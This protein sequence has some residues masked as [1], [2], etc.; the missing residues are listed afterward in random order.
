MVEEELAI[1]GVGAGL[2]RRPDADRPRGGVVALH[3]A[4]RPERSQPLFD[5]LADTLVPLGLAVL[6]YDRRS[7][8][9]DSDIPLIHQSAD[10]RQA[11]V[12]LAD[13][14]DAPVGLFG[15]SQGAWA[16]CVA[17]ATDADPPER[18]LVSFMMLLGCSGVSPAEQMRFYTDERLRRAG[19]D[20]SARTRARE[21]RVGLEDTFRR[22]VDPAVTDAAL[23]AAGDEPWFGLTYLPP[24]A[25]GPDA[26]WEDMDFDPST[27]IAR[28]SCPTLLMW[29]QDEECVP[30]SESEAVW[31]SHGTRDLTVVHLPGCGHFPVEGGAGTAEPA[32]TT[33]ISPGYTN[34]LTSWVER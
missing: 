11:L 21:L 26:M 4:A 30:A 14:I 9:D 34:A 1:P 6:S 28:V 22:L 27:Q 23:R 2:L 18:M 20:S 3:G 12:T 33:P 10:A 17:A 31:R 13:H 15:F 25:P 19:Y 32:D 8:G 5:H 24:R 16:A 7:S 29:G